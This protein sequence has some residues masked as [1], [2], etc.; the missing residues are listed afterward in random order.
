MCVT[1]LSD[2]TGA[3]TLISF[4]QEIKEIYSGSQEPQTGKSHG[5]QFGKTTFSNRNGKHKDKMLPKCVTLVMLFMR[6]G[7]KVMN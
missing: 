5:P 4:W 3:V 7:K 1:I 2:L 6:F